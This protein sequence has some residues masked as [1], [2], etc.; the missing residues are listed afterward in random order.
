M[1]IEWNPENIEKNSFQIIRSEMKTPLAHPEMEDILVRVIHTTADFTY[2]D[3]LHFKLGSL[4]KPEE[5][6]QAGKKIYTD[7]RMVLSGI[8][9]R[10]LR[11][12]GMEVYCLVDD[13]EVASLAKEQGRTR[14]A[15][16]VEKAAT[17]P[18]TSIFVFG[19]APTALFRLCQ[20]I[21][22]G[23]ADPALII[24]VPVGFVGAVESKE[25]LLTYEVPSI[26]VQGRKGGSTVAA[27]IVNALLKRK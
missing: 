15:V 4:S 13:P 20:L 11:S 12:L 14:S 8:N 22:E 18:E 27:A 26:S 5:A 3:A 24:G 6:L 10:I 1:E 16:A 7:T 9:K 2:A 25:A 17:D 23:K 21:D 19:N